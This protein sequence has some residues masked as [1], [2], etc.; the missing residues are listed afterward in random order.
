MT[1]IATIGT[2]EGRPVEEITLTSK[3]GATAKIMTWGAVVRDM[4]VP[5]KGQEAACGARLRRRSSPIRSIPPI[6]ERWPAAS[7]TASDGVPSS[8]DG[9]KVQVD[10]NQN[11][12]RRV[13]AARRGTISMAESAAS[14]SSSGRS[15]AAPSEN[16]VTLGLVS[17]DGDQGY[18]GTMTATCTYTLG[19]ARDAARRAF[20]DD[21][22]AHDR[23]SRASFL[24][25]PRR[26][27]RT[28]RT[29]C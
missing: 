14:A 17:P 10:L 6:S 11:D 25:E 21:G 22:Q 15:C 5:H 19:R 13:P 1:A 8:L 9:R 2:Y 27:R 28:S 26:L 29:I 7:P 18:P 3:A 12:P 4:H 16:S 24:L 20:G 23:Q